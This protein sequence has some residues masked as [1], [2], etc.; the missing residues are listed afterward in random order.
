[1][2]PDV[3][4][5]ARDIDIAWEDIATQFESR[6]NRHRELLQKDDSFGGA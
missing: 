6:V 2:I 5:D 4:M 1:V 3:I